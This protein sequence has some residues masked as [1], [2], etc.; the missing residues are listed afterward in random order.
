MV[1]MGAEGKPAVLC[2]APAS[3]LNPADAKMSSKSLE[4]RRGQAQPCCICS[5][6]GN[7]GGVAGLLTGGNSFSAWFLVKTIIRVYIL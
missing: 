5:V 6:I 2:G 3:C 4:Y 7:T 1:N